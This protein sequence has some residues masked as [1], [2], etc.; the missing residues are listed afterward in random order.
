MQRAICWF[1]SPYGDFGTLTKLDGFEETHS[2]KFQSPYGD[3]G[4]LTSTEIGL[5]IRINQFQSPYGDF[6]TLTL[7]PST[8]SQPGLTG[9]FFKP[10]AFFAFSG[11]PGEK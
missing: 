11:D 5:S 7:S 8:R 1:Q 2:F 6:G 4:T 9:D 10:P 3:F